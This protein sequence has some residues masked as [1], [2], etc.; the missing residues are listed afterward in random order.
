[1]DGN[2][3]SLGNAEQRALVIKVKG[4]KGTKEYRLPLRG[5][6]KMADVM[7]FRVPKG[8][9]E[10]Q[11]NDFGFDAF[12]SFACRYVPEEA[13]GSLTEGEFTQLYQAWDELSDAE[14]T[15]GE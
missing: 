14:V 7:L 12:W 8:L 15:Q 6:L 13:L 1:M 3:I 10:E 5:D 2:S 9:S 11:R 4:A